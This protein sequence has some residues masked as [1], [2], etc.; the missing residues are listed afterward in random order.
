[1]FYGSIIQ[2]VGFANHASFISRFVATFRQ[3]LMPTPSGLLSLQ[4]IYYPELS[5]VCER[6]LIGLSP[7]IVLPLMFTSVVG[8]IGTRI[9]AA[10]HTRVV[11]KGAHWTPCPRR[12][13][14]VRIFGPA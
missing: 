5:L 4:Q 11:G 10:L 6:L 9:R 1:M 14:A 2:I 8:L 12:V 13:R 3:W 7:V